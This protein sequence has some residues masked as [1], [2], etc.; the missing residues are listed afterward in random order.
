MSN[1]KTIKDPDTDETLI[2]EELFDSI[3]NAKDFNILEHVI[4]SSFGATIIHNMPLDQQNYVIEEV[5]EFTNGYQNIFDFVQKALADPAAR[6]K[7]LEM[8]REK[9]KG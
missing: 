2:D 8:A 1:D 4:S 9:F 5:K 7:F 3:E 6:D